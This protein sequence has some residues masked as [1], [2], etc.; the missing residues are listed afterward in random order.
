MPNPTRYRLSLLAF[1]AAA[2][3]CALTPTEWRHRQD[4]VVAAPGLVQVDLGDET[5]NAAAPGL[6]DLRVVGPDGREVSVYLSRHRPAPPKVVR[7]DT[8][9]VR[10][11]AGMTLI[12]M[13]TRES[14]G[15]DSVTLE[16]PAP[17]FLRAANVSRPSDPSPTNQQTPIFREHGAERLTLP[18]PPGGGSLSIQVIDG[19]EPPLPFTGALLSV[20]A[21]PE[22]TLLLSPAQITG[23][24]EFAGETVCTVRLESRQLPLAGLVI[25]SPEP[26]F[27]RQVTVAERVVTDGVPSERRLGSGAIF[28]V[29][30]G[31]R[32]A[33]ELLQ[34]PL[35]ANPSGA[36]LLVHVANGDAPPLLISR[37]VAKRRPVTLFFLAPGPGTYSLL[38]GNSQAPA[39]RYDL[40]PFADRIKESE[41]TPVTAGPVQDMPDYHP[42]EALQAKAPELEI[43]LAGAPLDPS[44]W[45]SRRPVQ[46]AAPG[47]QELELDPD[48]LARCREDFADLRLLRAGNQVP[49]ILERTSLARS[50]TLSAQG[51][52]D[53]K[54]P[55]A[56]QW[57]V[58]LPN[59]GLPLRSVVL[60]S[61]TPLF[62]RQVRIFERVAGSD[63]ATFDR[64]LAHGEWTRTAQPESPETHV[65]PLS[66]RLQTDTLWIETDNGDNAAIGLGPVTANLPVV[67]LVFKTAETDGFELAAGNATVGPPS[68]DLGL[69]AGRLLTASRTDAH[70]GAEDAPPSHRNPFAH[71]SG[72]VLF[73]GALALVVFVL[74]VTVSKLLPKP[75]G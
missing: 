34:V 48:T 55:A 74:L 28:R 26:L 58:T 3:A 40:E 66:D 37:V 67:R 72:G 12:T 1:L 49:Y 47:V 44:G 65:F 59:P 68:Y 20:R 8:F 15:V 14:N 2:R 18:V 54:R 64:P 69:V 25:D 19:K 41:A 39:G 24:D 75:P 6:S 16:T 57:K 45:A 71:L 33:T 21:G 7:P 5:F 73:W 42:A 35:S 52:T 17:F 10:I 50:L 23:R 61:T 27:Q 4:L 30:L 29:S 22:P 31:N 51:V 53:A 13:E 43:P 70:L 36:E 11:E 9:D 46:L 63:G 62:Q 32:P 56:S 60:T 38:T